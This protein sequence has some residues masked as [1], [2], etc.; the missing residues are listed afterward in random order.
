MK[1][2]QMKMA[3][4]QVYGILTHT[5]IQVSL[6]DFKWL[7]FFIVLDFLATAFVKKKKKN[8]KIQGQIGFC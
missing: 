3:E 2:Q 7:F 5:D 1:A 6:D 4:D 8:G